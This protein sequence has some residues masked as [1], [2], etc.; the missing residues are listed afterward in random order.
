MHGDG[1]K[2]YRCRSKRKRWHI[3]IS[4]GKVGSLRRE[5]ETDISESGNVNMW[6]QYG[7]ISRKFLLPVWVLQPCIQSRTS[8]YGWFF[9]P[10][11]I[12]QLL[13]C[14][15]GDCGYFY[16][17][18]TQQRLRNEWKATQVTIATVA[19]SEFPLYTP[20][21]FAAVHSMRGRKVSQKGLKSLT[22]F[23]FSDKFRSFAIKNYSVT[24]D[25]MRSCKLLRRDESCLDP[26]TQVLYMVC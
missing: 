6:K 15:C 20:H 3:T 11:Y 14:W 9:P 10:V 25:N 24:R 23:F 8:K 21:S 16:M 12:V 5:Y 22:C 17:A 18:D 7:R 1:S 2:L 4:W 19:P 26:Q 13:R